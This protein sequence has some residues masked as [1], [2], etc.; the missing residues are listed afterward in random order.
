MKVY[1]M[2][3]ANALS[4]IDDASRTLSPEGEIEVEQLG[5]FLQSR[6]ISV[7]HILHS[8]KTRA[9]QTAQKLAPYVNCEHVMSCSTGINEEDDTADMLPVVAAWESDTL[10]V[11]HLP[12]I[13]RLVSAMVSDNPD[14][15]IVTFPT[16]TLVCLNK[17][18]DENW[19]IEWMLNPQLIGNPSA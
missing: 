18:D 1:C 12:F 8:C 14:K 13:E 19:S 6:N 17:L 3:H 11:S 7:D 5:K 2:R 15:N 4:E 10:I 16:C 9:E